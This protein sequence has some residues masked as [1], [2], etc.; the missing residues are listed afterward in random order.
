MTIAHE[1]MYAKVRKTPDGRYET[2]NIE[3]HSGKLIENLE[4]LRKLYKHD[5]DQIEEVR[6]KDYDLWE[7]LIICALFHD[8]G[9]FSPQFQNKLRK[10]LGL[11]LLALDGKLRK[12]IPH[13]FLSVAFL[14]EEVLDNGALAPYIFYAIAHHHSRDVPRDEEYLKK[15]LRL[16]NIQNQPG[17]QSLLEKHGYRPD[18]RNIWDTYLPYL[19]DVHKYEEIR[20]EPFFVALKGLLHRLD[21]SSSAGVPVEVE[22]IGDPPG[23]MIRALKQKVEGSGGVFNGLKEFQE[24]A[25]EHRNSNVILAAST[26]MGKTEFAVNW[27]WNDKGFYTL[28]LRVSVDAMYDRM[29]YMFGHEKIGL[30]HGGDLFR[31]HIGGNNDNDDEDQDIKEFI[32]RTTLARQLSMPLTVT[33]A[34]QLFTSAFK[35]KGYEQIYATLMYSKVILDEPQAYSSEILAT[36]VTA[37]QEI[38]TLGGKFCVMSATLHPFITEELKKC[39]DVVQM[40]VYNDEIKHKL[41]LADSDIDGLVPEIDKAYESGKKV[42]VICN[43]VK[44]SQDMYDLLKHL[45]NVKLLHAGF[46]VRDRAKKEERIK[47]DHNKNDRVA[48]ITTQIVEASLDIDYDIL[49]TELATID[50]LIQRMG[51]I[52]RKIGRILRGHDPANI[53]I[54]CRNPSDKGFI[55]SE[56]LVGFTLEAL[57]GFDGQAIRETEKEGLMAEVFDYDRV[58]NTDLYKKFTK[59]KDLLKYGFEAES[60]SEAQDLFRRISNATVIPSD[61]YNKN[62]DVIDESVD[63]IGTSGTPVAERMKAMATI[64]GFTVDIP[65]YRTKDKSISRLDKKGRIHVIDLPYGEKGIVFKKDENDTSNFM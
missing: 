60:K 36:I 13:N 27:L 47:E 65:I 30:L 20:K 44:K 31:A 33:T 26:G 18:F 53:V 24:K 49:F 45:G 34:D 55:Y 48:W 10:I 1:I 15:V 28:P 19:K 35:W 52:L 4:L 43:T 39:A 2:E 59:Y 37:L 14:P 38:A 64:R 51:R 6:S 40:T 32:Y 3:E 62:I 9:K 7:A 11:A 54:A 57:S 50:A 17:Y 8:I 21:Y 22:R 46:I 56:E 16:C 61:V 58:K 63:K 29:C 42:L 5:I 23:I 25:K 41:R 12:E